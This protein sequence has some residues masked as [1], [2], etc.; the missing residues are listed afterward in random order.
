MAGLG[1][2]ALGFAALLIPAGAQRALVVDP[3]IT[4]RGSAQS[5]A[6]AFSAALTI[7][8]AGGLTFGL[9][10]ALGTFVTG[11]AL[12]SGL[13]AFAPWVAPFLIQALCRA[14][15]RSATVVA[16]PLWQCPLRRS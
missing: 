4:Y 8:L 6:K 10:F 3:Y 11:G 12:R 9:I 13:L 2:V 16:R 1:A 7:S 14:G 15:R 5:D